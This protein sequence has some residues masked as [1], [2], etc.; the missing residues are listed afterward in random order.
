MGFAARVYEEDFLFYA[1]Q[2]N[3]ITLLEY[4]NHAFCGLSRHFSAYK[5]L[6]CYTLYITIL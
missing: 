5:P 3:L 6:S 2:S 4:D 1:L